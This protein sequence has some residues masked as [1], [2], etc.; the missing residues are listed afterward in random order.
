MGKGGQGLGLAVEAGVPAGVAGEVLGQD[1]QG[2]LA[3]ELGVAGFPDLAHAADAEARLDLVMPQG[4][5]CFHGN[6][7]S[8]AVKSGINNC[9]LAIIIR[10]SRALRL[11]SLDAR[12]GCPWISLSN[13][14]FANQ[15]LTKPRFM[16]C[17]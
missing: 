7:G 16:I 5:A 17:F 10:K 11:V 1:L 13:L 14:I 6:S 8:D 15:E 2:D 9:K 12:G 4:S 3:V